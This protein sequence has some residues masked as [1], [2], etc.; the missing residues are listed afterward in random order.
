MWSPHPPGC[1]VERGLP[2]YSGGS[3]AG[4]G[5]Q[6]VV[7]QDAP[8]VAQDPRDLVRPAE[9]VRGDHPGADVREEGVEDLLLALAQF[10]V[11]LSVD[12][13]GRGEVPEGREPVR[14]VGV[15]DHP[16]QR[17]GVTHL[18]DPWRAALDD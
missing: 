15:L 7:A 18:G 1:E 8:L 16:P 5:L 2:E 13:D 17:R 14:V 3:R 11:A 4:G 10:L 12:D 9:A 6:A